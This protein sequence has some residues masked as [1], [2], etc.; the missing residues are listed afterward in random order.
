MTFCLCLPV[1]ACFTRIV[2]ENDYKYS[3]SILVVVVTQ[4]RKTSL[5]I[6]HFLVKLH[7]MY[8]LS[9]LPPSS[10]IKISLPIIVK[11]SCVP[12]PCSN[13]AI[14]TEMDDG[15]HCTCKM[16]HKGDRCQSKWRVNIVC[17]SRFFDQSGCWK[18]SG[19]SR[20]YTK[21]FYF[22]FLW[23]S[24]DYYSDRT[25]FFLMQKKRCVILTPAK[26]ARRVLIEMIGS[27]NV[28]ALWDSKEN[29]VRVCNPIR[30]V[31]KW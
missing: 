16:G 5:C 13:E 4:R 14:C 20:I 23:S 31:V 30:F 1:P 6:I 29:Y 3:Q 8:N 21:I 7:K 12:N 15:Y 18:C 11:D 17:D 24:S 19:R 25:P 10:F 27:L 26:M 2:V 22:W 28:L 9:W